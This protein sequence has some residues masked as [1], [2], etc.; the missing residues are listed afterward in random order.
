[1]IITE[2]FDVSEDDVA[3]GKLEEKKKFILAKIKKI[4]DL[5]RKLDKIP[6]TRR[7][8]FTR[9]RII[10]AMSADPR[11]EYARDQGADHRNPRAQ[12]RII[13]DLEERREELRSRRNKT[14]KKTAQDLE[15]Q[16]K[17]SRKASGR[18]RRTSAW[19]P[20]ISAG[21]SGRSRPAKRSA[22]GQERAGRGQHHPPGRLDHQPATEGL[23]FLD[24]IQEGN[25]GA[26]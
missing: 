10:V 6:N 9:S 13:N 14:R 24:L 11:P 19:T 2:V 20:L 4:K 22:T 12:L 3:E 5:G 8:V 1:M 26:R 18:P 15:P 17:R 21:S 23:Q 7:M 16:I 25:M